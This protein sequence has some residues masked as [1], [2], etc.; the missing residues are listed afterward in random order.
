M[1]HDFQAIKAQASFEKVLEMLGVPFKLSGEQLRAKCPIC[2][3]PNERGLVCT[4]SKGLYYCFHEKKGGDVIKL[5]SLALKISE[6]EAAGKI[7]KHLDIDGDKTTTSTAEPVT[8]AKT[9]S[10]GLQPLDYLQTDWDGRDDLAVSEE[11]LKHFGVGY[12]PKGMMQGRLAIPLHDTDGK[13]VA[14]VG[15]AMKPE[16]AQ[17]RYKFPKDFVPDLI[18]NAHRIEGGILY[19]ITK[20]DVLAVLQAFENGVTNTVAIM[21]NLTLPQTERLLALMRDKGVDALELF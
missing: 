16:E 8:T 5:V 12:A 10:V 14:Y 15:V 20:G 6:K 21:G 1:Y 9:K 4:P 19:V 2:N 17:Q 7:A 3:D 13:L 11:T 18:F